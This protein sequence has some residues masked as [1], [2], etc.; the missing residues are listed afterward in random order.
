M[1]RDEQRLDFCPMTQNHEMVATA[2][3]VVDFVERN[4]EEGVSVSV[5]LDRVVM[6]GRTLPGGCIQTESADKLGIGHSENRE[7]HSSM[8]AEDKSWKEH[9]LHEPPGHD[10]AELTNFAKERH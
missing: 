3:D 4:W 2:D 6:N 9:F 10:V 1:P 7:C 5:D 8:A